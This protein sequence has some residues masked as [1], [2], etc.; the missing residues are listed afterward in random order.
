MKNIK[1]GLLLSVAVVVIG[2]VF[3]GF[4]GYQASVTN[5]P[6]VTVYYE[7]RDKSQSHAIVSYVMRSYRSDGSFYSHTTWEQQDGSGNKNYASSRVLSLINVGDYF[8]DHDEGTS[9][10]IGLTDWLVTEDI[11]GLTQENLQ[12]GSETLPVYKITDNGLDRYWSDTLQVHLKQDID[13]ELYMVAYEY[14]DSV[15]EGYFDL[16][17]GPGAVNYNRFIYQTKTNL[18]SAE[19]ILDP[20]KRNKAIAFLNKGLEVV[21]KDWEYVEPKSCDLKAE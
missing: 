9:E 7:V 14:N 18:A 8:V 21:P 19:K 10:Y 13:P 1:I 3:G 2:L 11:T 20:V 5:R 16:P 12:V 4:I 17:G 15:D 6:E